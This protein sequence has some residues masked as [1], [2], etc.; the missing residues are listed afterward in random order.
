MKK[1]KFNGFPVGAT[2]GL[3]SDDID[4]E[5]TGPVDDHVLRRSEVTPILRVLRPSPGPRVG[6]NG[7]ANANLYL[8]LMENKIAKLSRVGLCSAQPSP[9]A[10]QP[11]CFSEAVEL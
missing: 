11:F 4:R 9:V 10:T 6:T 8:Y 3:R 2:R 1:K 7:I 5:W